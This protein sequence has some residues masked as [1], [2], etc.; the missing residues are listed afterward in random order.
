MI[1]KFFQKPFLALTRILINQKLKEQE[2]YF[3]IV[4]IATMKELI[5]DCINTIGA[6]EISWFGT[7]PRSFKDHQDNLKV[8]IL[9]RVWSRMHFDWQRKSKRHYYWKKNS[10]LS[11][12]KRFDIDLSSFEHL[13]NNWCLENLIRPS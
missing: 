6:K 4:Q 2:M 5:T 11:N 9:N 8:K 13:S 10:K 3:L 1:W 12:H 7:M